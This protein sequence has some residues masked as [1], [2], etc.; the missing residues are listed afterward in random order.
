MALCVYLD[1]SIARL[2]GSQFFFVGT[3]ILEDTSTLATDTATENRTNNHL[4]TEFCPVARI[5]LIEQSRTPIAKHSISHPATEYEA[6]MTD[7]LA[8][9]RKSFLLRSFISAT[10]KLLG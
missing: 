7:S 4:D 9:N 3:E 6:G 5:P 1:H 2:I 10:V 8:H